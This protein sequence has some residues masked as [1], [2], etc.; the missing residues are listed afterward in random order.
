MDRTSAGLLAGWALVL[1]S[2]VLGLGN[3]YVQW[4]S[5]RLD[6]QLSNAPADAGSWSNEP[7]TLS[8]G[9]DTTYG[10]LDGSTLVLPAPIDWSLTLASAFAAG[11]ALILV[12][13]RARREPVGPVP[14]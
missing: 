13:V 7:R 10:L 11:I 14:V 8:L 3:L 6:W 4:Q 1:A 12:C 5:C 2:P 9:C